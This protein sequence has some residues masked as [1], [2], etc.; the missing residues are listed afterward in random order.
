MLG[1]RG[2]GLSGSGL[3]QVAGTCERVS[4]SLC[5]YNGAVGVFL[6]S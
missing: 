3:G 1:R 6:S 5:P 2:V 4:C